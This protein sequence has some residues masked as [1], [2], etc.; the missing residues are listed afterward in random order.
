MDKMFLIQVKTPGNPVYFGGFKQVH[1]HQ[2]PSLTEYQSHAKPWKTARG[3]HH[4]R[5]V[6]ARDFADYLNVLAPDML[7]MSVI[8]VQGRKT[9]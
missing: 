1:G 2:Y 3:A 8:A 4:V 7:E 9:A 6:L 5:K